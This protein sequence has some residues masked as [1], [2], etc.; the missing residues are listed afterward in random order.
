MSY[1]GK[2]TAPL[3]AL[4]TG[5]PCSGRYPVALVIITILPPSGWPFM[6]RAASETKS[7][8]PCKFTSI[9]RWRGGSPAASADYSAE[10]L[11]AGLRQLRR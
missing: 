8:V 9:V 4:Y 11:G 6:I 3:V 1:R 7:S 5:I 2:L 10:S